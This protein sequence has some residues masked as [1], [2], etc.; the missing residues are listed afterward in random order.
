MYRKFENYFLFVFTSGKENET[1]ML[2]YSQPIIR[3]AIGHT[4]THA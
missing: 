2:I 4:Y 3:A 1:P